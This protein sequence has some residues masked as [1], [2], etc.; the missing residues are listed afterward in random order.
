M[1]PIEIVFTV[2][3]RRKKT[4]TTS[5]KLA[6]VESKA[7][8]NLFAVAW[9]NVLDNITSGVIR[10]ATAILGIDL[11]ALTSNTVT[12]DSDVE[13][14]AS[15]QFRSEEGTKV[16]IN[17]PAILETLVVNETGD[18]DPAAPQ[19]AAFLAMMEDGIGVTGGTIIP[20]DIGEIG[21]LTNVYLRE[22]SRN[23]GTRKAGA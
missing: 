19:V 15:A 6:E 3:D 9:A 13:E 7:R 10:S 22:R 11:S 4:A 14:I 2:E 1:P 23:S 5:I 8:V 17:I 16:E 21:G 18:L 20:C 12:N